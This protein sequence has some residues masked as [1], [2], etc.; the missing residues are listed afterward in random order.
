[1]QNVSHKVCPNCGQPAILQM[2]ICRRCGFQFPVPA[3]QFE[4]NRVPPAQRRSASGMA[5]FIAVA[6]LILLVLLGGAIVRRRNRLHNGG[7][8]DFASGVGVPRGGAPAGNVESPPDLTGGLFKERPGK[9]EQPTIYVENMETG[10][11]FM[12][13]RDTQGRVYRS[14]CRAGQRVPMQ[15]PAGNY[16][17]HVSSDVPGIIAS[18]GDAV[19]RTFKEY[20]AAFTFGMPGEPL[21][22]GD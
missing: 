22:L 1:M 12:E 6:L 20:D 19:F 3:E 18:D 11:L 10:T 16:G 5:V 8:G 2:P 13:L 14:Q 4:R 21:H 7:I 17:V 15:V 9:A